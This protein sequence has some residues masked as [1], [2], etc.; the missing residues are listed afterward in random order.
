MVKHIVF[1]RLKEEAEGHSKQENA[2]IIR[3]G[4]LSLLDKIP[5]LRAETVGLNIPN[6]PKT[7][8]DI[9]LECTFDSWEDLNAY[10]VHPEHVKVASYIGLCKEARAAVD[11]EY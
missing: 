2:V 11:Y 6:A 4:L 3:D 1:F 7:D 9:C 10:Q 5:F 8:H